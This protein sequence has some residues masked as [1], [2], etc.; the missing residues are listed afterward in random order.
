MLII[1]NIKNQLQ[2]KRESKKLNSY[3]II[4]PMK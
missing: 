4:T 1:S 3:F 2:G